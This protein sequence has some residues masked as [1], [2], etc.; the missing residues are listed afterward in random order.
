MLNKT[1]GKIVVLCFSIIFYSCTSNKQEL[2]GIW[3]EETEANS[4]SQDDT[5]DVSGVVSNMS[6]L[7]L[8]SWDARICLAY[9]EL[10]LYFHS[11]RPDGEGNYD[12]WVSTRKST[13]DEWEEPRNIGAPI[14]TQYEDFGVF[15]SQDNLVLYFCSDRPGGYGLYDIWYSTRK[16]V[17][18]NW[19]DPINLGSKINSEY[20]EIGPSV[21]PD[22]LEFYFSDYR[23]FVP[24]PG[25]CG[26]A[27]IWVSTR[28]RI[29]SSWREPK[30]IGSK[31]NSKW[32]DY[33]LTLSRDGLFLFFTS[34]RGDYQW[35]E[36]I[37]FSS[38]D[39]ILSEWKSAK[40]FNQVI[41]SD[42]NDKAGWISKDR[43]E[44]YFGSDRSGGKGSI[45]LWRIVLDRPLES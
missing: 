13:T 8:E 30:N 4:I 41:N 42:S 43:K 44:L 34:K 2:K 37:W 22:G 23:S 11:D 32:D 14:N 40:K 7:N 9:D 35:N 17:S 25:G 38:R 24:R 3:S 45:D 6:K 19:N 5:Q 12:I 16:N 31:V 27:D 18:E 29:E 10:T 1:I 21:S 20:N 26:Q 33:G 39:S 36:N 15:I 28:E